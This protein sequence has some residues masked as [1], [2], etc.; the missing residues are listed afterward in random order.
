MI[1]QLNTNDGRSSTG[2]QVVNVWKGRV[3]DDFIT[4]TREARFSPVYGGS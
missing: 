2:S 1:D 4:D 3:Y